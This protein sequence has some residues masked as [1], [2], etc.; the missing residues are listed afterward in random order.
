LACILESTIIMAL[1]TDDD[2]IL[3]LHNAR[4]SKSRAALKV[5]EERGVKFEERSYL[6]T[7]L[8]VDELKDLAQRLGRPAREW[9]RKGEDAF[10]AA[11]IADSTDEGAWLDA[12]AAHPI[13]LERPIVIRGGRAVVGRPL[14]NVLE[15]LDS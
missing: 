7:P 14:T 1:P 8:S 12:I 4:C 11:A 9:T 13:L 15:L 5:L 2:T 6:E 10:A 3:L